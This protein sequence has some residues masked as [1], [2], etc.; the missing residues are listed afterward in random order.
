[1]SQRY[2]LSGTID[3]TCARAKNDDHTSVRIRICSQG[4]VCPQALSERVRQTRLKYRAVY[5]LNQVLVK[6]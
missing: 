2:R 3:M 6:A 4:V 5:R 1:M